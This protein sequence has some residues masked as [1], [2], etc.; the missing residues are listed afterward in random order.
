M[1]EHQGLVERLNQLNEVILASDLGL[2]S[3]ETAALAEAA[4]EEAQRAQHLRYGMFLKESIRIPTAINP[5]GSPFLRIFPYGRHGPTLS[6]RAL[7]GTLELKEKTWTITV[8][9]MDPARVPHSAYTLK[10]E[11]SMESKYSPTIKKKVP[12][13]EQRI[14]H[15]RGGLFGLPPG[16]RLSPMCPDGLEY[17]QP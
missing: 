13:Q 16:G 9:S 5:R 6:G 3:P 12:S 10:M 7:D 8:P 11:F 2:L 4:K 14:L 1:K 15:H 17:L